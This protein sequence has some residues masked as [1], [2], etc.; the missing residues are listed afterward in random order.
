M[1]PT[2]KTAESIEF[3]TLFGVLPVQ[4]VV[5]PKLNTGVRFPSPA[6]KTLEI[7]VKHKALPEFYYFLSN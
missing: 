7:P 2:A 4:I 5:I 1:R 3:T 6:P